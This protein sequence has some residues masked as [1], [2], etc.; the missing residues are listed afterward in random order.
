[1]KPPAI[2]GSLTLG[3]VS[4]LFCLF[5]QPSHTI[6][7]W[8]P[9]EMSVYASNMHK[10]R[11]MFHQEF[12][13]LLCGVWQCTSFKFHPDI[14]LQGGT[15]PLWLMVICSSAELLYNWVARFWRTVIYLVTGLDVN[16]WKV[17]SLNG[18]MSHMLWLLAL[19]CSCVAGRN[20][21]SLLCTHA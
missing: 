15:L 14:S 12:T 10:Y 7:K 19:K 8:L 6:F 2:L 18:D 4:T 13:R 9:D 21:W 3:I 5:E 16:T 11:L 20:A 17:Q 1:M